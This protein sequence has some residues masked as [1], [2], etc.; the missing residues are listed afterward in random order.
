MKDMSIDINV[1][2]MMNTPNGREELHL[3]THIPQGE[4]VC[5]LGWMFGCR[6][7]NPFMFPFRTWLPKIRLHKGRRRSV[8]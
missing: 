4:F 5:V 6:K 7:D 1:N 3:E 8:V 2:R